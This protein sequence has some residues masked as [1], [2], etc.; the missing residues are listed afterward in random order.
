MRLQPIVITALFGLATTLAGCVPPA[1]APAQS[2]TAPTPTEPLPSPPAKPTPDQTPSRVEWAVDGLAGAPQPFALELFYDG[3]A[4][5]FRILSADGGLVVALPIAGSGI[6]GPDTCV[7]RV[8]ASALHSSTWVA[9]DAALERR[10]ESEAASYR[11]ETTLLDGRLITV[12]LADSGCRDGVTAPTSNTPGASPTPIALPTFVQLAPTSTSALWAIVAGTHLFRSV[13]RGD[14]WTEQPLPARPLVNPEIAFVDD[15]EGWL[16]LNGPAATQCT[17]QN[18]LVFHTVDAGVSWQQI[19]SSGLDDQCK[20]GLVF[21]DRTHG[22]ISGRDA[23]HAPVIYRTTDGGRTWTGSQPLPDPPGFTTV[24]AGVTL[25]AGAVHAIGS[26]LLVQAYGQIGEHAHL[27]VFRSVDAGK[28]WNFVVEVTRAGAFAF[29]TA[30]RW[31]QIAL[32]D[33]SLETTDSGSS[34]HPFASDYSQAAGVAPLMIFA[35]ASTGYATVRGFTQRT[36][37]GGV[38]W[39]SIG[40]PL[41]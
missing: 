26:T 23:N 3:T 1:A 28:S 33:S 36:V 19:T 9:I 31:L 39:T 34:W 18:V 2:P 37:D 11:V 24:G 38:H 30:S 16:T 27:Y 7:N 13:D 21:A 15:R 4:M 20:A 12:P 29:V 10:F 5:G 35:S 22:Y 6:F 14:H 40:T 8:R 32:A 25:Q 41:P 17:F